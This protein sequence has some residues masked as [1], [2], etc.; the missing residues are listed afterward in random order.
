[1]NAQYTLPRFQP[2]GGA[3]ISVLLHLA[4]ALP[5]FIHATRTPPIS[6]PAA[7]MLEYAPDF[8][9]SVI[10]PALPPGVTQQRSVEAMTEQETTQQ[11][12]TPKVMEKEDAEVTLAAAKE[13][14]QKKKT[15]QVKKKAR[16][17]QREER[18]NSNVNSRAAPPVQ[19]VQAQRTAA[20]LDTDAAQAS[21]QQ[22]SWE[23]LV[24]GKINKMRNYPQDA[25]RRRRSGTVILTFSV[26]ASG[27]LLG[28]KLLAS[29]GT[30]SLDRAA[31][32]ALNNARPLPPPPSVILKGG[33]HRVT[34]PV[35]FEL[36][37]NR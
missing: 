20:P 6:I 5:F 18:G 10:Q 14:H 24:K 34:L 33:I 4:V 12:E 15:T 2:L 3:A 35:E 31:M 30:M 7:V 23:A 26:D 27:N 22:V 1:M 16:R 13:S 9:V 28:E 32:Q 36:S 37:Q 29:S 19:A 17:E 8:Q 11:K 25:R 21:S